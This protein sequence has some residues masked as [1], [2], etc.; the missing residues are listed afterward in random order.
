MPLEAVQLGRR[1]GAEPEHRFLAVAVL[2][3]QPLERVQPVIDRLQA[4]GLEDDRVAQCAHRRERLVHLY[5][6]GL[7]RLHGRRERGV[8]PAE[9]GQDAG[10]PGEPGR[11]GGGVVL[12]QR[13]D[14]LQPGCEPL[15][16]LEPLPFRPQLPLF[17]RTQPRGVQL[18]HLEAQEV[19]ALRAVAPGA[20][21]ALEIVARLAV[22]GEEGGEALAHRLRVAEPVEQVELARGLE[23]PLMLVLAVHLHERVAE[24]LEEADRD[25]R[26]VDEGAMAAAT[27]E[28]AA[29]HDLAVLHGQ[30]RLIEHGRHAAIGHGEHRLDGG[31]L[32][33]G[34]NH[35]GLRARAAYQENRVDQDGLAGAGLAGEDVEA[36]GEGDGDVL[37]HREV[38]DPQLAQHPA[39]MLGQPRSSL[40]MYPNAWGPDMAPHCRLSAR[41]T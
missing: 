8:Q 24:P 15:G 5:A 27:R 14:L 12:Q 38:P 4:A 26:V 10:R 6:R 28:L 36:G 32:G 19:L 21:A 17:A 20:A 40:K 9:V 30:S 39:T 41:P 37:D 13:A 22:L 7:Q 33:V 2:A 3:R 23:Q 16:V 35:I 18:G 29:D 1:L 25:R 34:A 11:R 31:G